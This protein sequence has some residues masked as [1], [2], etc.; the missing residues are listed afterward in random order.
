VGENLGV[1][2]TISGRRK[3]AVKIKKVQFGGGGGKRRG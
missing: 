1:G 2:A 3:V